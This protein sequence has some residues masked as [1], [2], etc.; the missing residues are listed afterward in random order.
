LRYGIG[1]IV[2]QDLLQNKNITPE[3]NFYTSTTTKIREA[4]LFYD[5][6]V[7]GSYSKTENTYT[8]A[9][10]IRKANNAKVLANNTFTGE[11]LLTLL[12]DISVFIASSVDQNKKNSLEYIDLPINE[13]MSNSL[14]ALEAFTDENYDKAYT[15]DP[16]FALAY[17]EEAKLNRKY[18]RGKL[19]TQDI[20]NK[21]SKYVSRLPLQKQLEVLIEK[22][23]AYGE[24]EEAEKQVKLQLEVD[25]HNIF[26]NNILFSIFG[27]TKNLEDYFKVSEELFKYNPSNVSGN[28]LAV[29]ALVAG[30]EKQL[31][32]ALNAFEIINPEIKSLKIE[33]LI[34]DGKIKEAKA[35]YEEFKISHSYNTNRNKIYDSIFNYLDDKPIDI[36]DLI[37][38]TGKY[39]SNI[40][41]QT[42]EYWIENE[43]LIEYIQNQTMRTYV[44]AGEDAF[45]GGFLQAVVFYAKLVKDDNGKIIGIIKSD[46]NWNNTFVRL[47]WKTDESILD[48]EEAFNND[49]LLE[50]EQ[51]YE[52][53]IANNPDHAYLKNILKHIQYKKNTD[54]IVRNDQ[55]Q[56]HSGVYG[57]RKFWFEEGKFYYKRKGEDSNL[58]KVELLP[59]SDSLYMDLTRLGTLMSFNKTN[60]TILS[61]SYN[62]N[63]DDFEWEQLKLG[64][65]TFEKIK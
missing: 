42:S 5:K 32:D 49:N 25:P 23:L 57:P 1:K 30:Y 6:Y 16:Y 41:E 53:A 19:E 2:Y 54:S 26:F 15:E 52:K 35:I 22:N 10:N 33:P 18:N 29:A 46:A 20:I 21:A 3:F 48:A 27:E 63:I 36:E 37:P 43:R 60:E 34:F 9:V 38:F 14:P 4:S 61:K 50:A 51:L 44:P 17:L 40:N 28:N 64:K 12:D 24:F 7:D 59:L 58:P 31:I 62:F 56:L 8:I 13:F 45:G 65:N 39:R 47:F 11:N 55:F